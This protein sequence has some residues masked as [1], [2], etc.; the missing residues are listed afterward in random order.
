MSTNYARDGI[1]HDAGKLR[2]DLVPPSA[3][4][5]LAEVLT[6]GASKYQPNTWQHVASERYHAAL[7]RHLCAWMRGERVDPESG[8]SHLRHVLC[9]AAF[10]VD[11]EERPEFVMP[12]WV[13]DCESEG[14]E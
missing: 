11:Q 13:S 6:Y 1:K 5:A 12:R 4:E 10:L 9:N 3:L 14:G 8:I 2:M 7:L